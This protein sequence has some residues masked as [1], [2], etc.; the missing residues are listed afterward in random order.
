MATD[1]AESI[2][3]WQH[4]GEHVF[5]TAMEVFRPRSGLEVW[6]FVDEYGISLPP[7]VTRFPGPLQLSRTPYML[8]EWGPLWAFRRF[9]ETDNVYG[10]QVG[11]TLMM[12][13]TVCYV[14]AV[15]PG[16]GMIIY[17]DQHTA[18][19]RS[20]EHMKP[21]IRENMQEYLTSDQDDFKNLRYR[22]RPCT[23]NIGWAGSPSVLAGEPEKYVWGDEEALWKEKTEKVTDSKRLAMRR[24]I[25]YGEF[26]RFFGCTTPSLETLPGWRDWPHSTQCQFYVPC[27][28]CGHEQVLYFGHEDRKWFVQEDDGWDGGIKWDRSEKLSRDERLASA[29]YQCEACGGAFGDIEANDAIARG[30]WIARYPDAVK[31][32]SQLPS[33]YAPWVKF[34]EV[35]DRWFSSYKDEQARHDF[36]NNDCAVPYE[37]EGH[38]AEVSTLKTHI[39]QGHHSGQVPQDAAALILTADVHDDH[40]RYRVRAHA[41]DTTSWGVDEGQILPD[42]YQ[43]DHVLARAYQCVGRQV[44]ISAGLIDARWRTDEVLQ[45]CL[46]HDGWMWPAM[47]QDSQRE[48]VDYQTRA[49]I[50]DPEQGLYLQGQIV[51]VN[52]NDPRWK[53]LLFNRLNVTRGEAGYWYLEEEV[54]EEFLWQMTGEEKRQK[55]NTKNQIVTEW[56]LKHDN[57]ALDCEKLQLV[58]QTVFQI[59]SLAVATEPSQA[60]TEPA[61]NPYTGE[62]IQQ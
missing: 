18:D 25:S 35:L 4:V 57:H 48:A 14:I 42:L 39:A 8:G 50:P 6:E 55:R 29:Y 7:R 13:V 53:Q 20:Q 44:S 36:W 10:A 51:V 59:S 15:D 11:K 26:A 45:F 34:S 62:Q 37:E 23:I 46:R 52:F 56:H 49:V 27:P 9:R 43:L 16:P 24:M 5:G 17:P 22:M 41:P 32:C 54:S 28:L 1:T 33:W 30:R 2:D 60:P 21:M 12:Q 38:G 47:G 61:I 31:Y 19:R 3:L 58:A 40:I